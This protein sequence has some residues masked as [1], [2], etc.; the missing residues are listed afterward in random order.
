MSFHERLKEE[1]LR[2][3]LSQDRFSDL[4]GLTKNTLRRYETGER[5]PDAN[6][7]QV[8][9]G[10]GLDIKYLFTGMREKPTKSTFGSRLKEERERF[11]Y[12]QEEAAEVALVRREIW[13][14]Y[15]ADKVDPGS[16]VLQRFGE[17]GADVL[18]ILTG[19]KEKS[20]A[21]S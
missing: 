10:H 2:M 20:E 17:H 5:S 16:K 7:L 18:Y 14:K 21:A 19:K 12:T 8:L 4:G 6:F 15:E 13:C 11:G 9:I 3:G 1:R